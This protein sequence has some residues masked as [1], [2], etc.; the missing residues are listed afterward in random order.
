MVI[1]ETARRVFAIRFFSFFLLPLLGMD[2]GM[3]SL[4]LALPWTL[5]TTWGPRESQWELTA[6]SWF[7]WQEAFQK[8]VKMA[9]S[10]LA[11]HEGKWTRIWAMGG[12]ARKE[13]VYLP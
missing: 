2:L 12:L 5:R 13:S 1:L 6:E 8:W 11:Q 4:L 9:L 10:H 3:C 7:W